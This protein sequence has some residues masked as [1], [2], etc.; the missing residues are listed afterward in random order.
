MSPYQPVFRNEL[1]RQ[2]H[3]LYQGWLALAEQHRKENACRHES[4]R[5]TDTDCPLLNP[6]EPA[7]SR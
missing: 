7:S 3:E 6:A 4:G 2:W 1:C 5:S